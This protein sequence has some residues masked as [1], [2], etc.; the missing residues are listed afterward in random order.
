[1]PDNDDAHSTSSS[2]GYGDSDVEL[3]GYS[4]GCDMSDISDDDTISDYAHDDG[5]DYDDS[6]SSSSSN[7]YPFF[8]PNPEAM[9]YEQE[10]I[11][12]QAQDAVAASKPKI[13]VRM[14]VDDLSSSS[15]E[16]ATA[17]PKQEDH[18]ASWCLERV[19]TAAALCRPNSPLEAMNVFK[20]SA[21]AIL[22]VAKEAL[23]AGGSLF[24]DGGLVET[25][26]IP[27]IKEL[28]AIRKDYYFTDFDEECF[29]LDGG[30]TA[31][32]NEF[33]RLKRIRDRTGVVDL[34]PSA[35]TPPAPPCA[36]PTDP[37]DGSC[38]SLAEGE[39]VAVTPSTPAS[40][41]A[42]PSVPAPAPA[43]AST[44]AS[45]PCAPPTD[46][47][48]GSCSSPEEGEEMAVTPTPAS[49]SASTS[50]PAPAPAPASTT[51]GPPSAPLTDSKDGSCSSP[52]EGEEMVVTGG[53]GGGMHVIFDNQAGSVI[54]Q[55]S[56]AVGEFAAPAV[57]V[58]FVRVCA[59]CMRFIYCTLVRS[60]VY[61]Q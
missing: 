15:I 14:M 1:M 5:I 34:E 53:G 28:D 35:S 29:K 52:A 55:P 48:Y 51:P 27:A 46:P 8:Q 50:V 43:P 18:T 57:R 26:S 17:D 2:Y 38:S 37:E 12:T 30:M 13:S 22:G 6:S 23:L 4:A 36:P 45:P 16:L 31:L 24:E 60:S 3:T 42:L 9:Q 54:Y 39:E 33:I 11:N 61:V 41:S 58:L 19:N 59:V 10:D 32:W 56:L 20:W 25:A 47:V 7:S 49:P 21:K 44:P 40:P